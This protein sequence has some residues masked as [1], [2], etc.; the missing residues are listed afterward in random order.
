ME[1]QERCL[2]SVAFKGKGFTKA[3]VKLMADILH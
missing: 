1:G 3:L 2:E